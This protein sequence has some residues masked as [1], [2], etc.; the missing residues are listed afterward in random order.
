MIGRSVRL[1]FP[2]ELQ[3]EESRTLRIIA[4]GQPIAHQETQHITKAGLRIDV[5]RTI[6]PIKNSSGAVIGVSTIAR[7]I[8]Q[9]KQVEEKLRTTEKLAATGRL[10]ATIAHEINNP[11]EA[12]TNLLYLAQ[13]D[14]SASPALRRY[15]QIA[16]EELNRVAHLAKQTLG[17]YRDTSSPTSFSAA[18]TVEDVLT[19]YFRRAAGKNVRIDR[20][21]D[22]NIQAFG[23]VGEFRQVLSNLLGNALDAIGPEGGRLVI[24][25]RRSWDWKH[26]QERLR[27]TVADTGVGIPAEMRSKVFDAFF[28][29]KSHYGTGLG[30]WLSHSIVQRHGGS[31]RLYSSVAPHRNGTVVSFSWPLAPEPLASTE[32]AA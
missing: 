4:S 25:A 22:P 19:L 23:F 5:A 11:L 31:I 9:Q 13:T 20:Q 21:L 1:L 30:L 24:R 3:E 29:T 32:R 7:D 14:A 18:A 10:A 27:I 12:V 6:S 8:T 16:D 15:L 28:T 17:F 2:P 26:Q